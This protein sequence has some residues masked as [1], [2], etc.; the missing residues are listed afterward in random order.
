MYTDAGVIAGTL[1]LFNS[2][3]LQARSTTCLAVRESD[4]LVL[5]AYSPS[6]MQVTCH[7]KIPCQVLV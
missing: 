1:T 6:D 2:S 5:A 7:A 4:G 3:F